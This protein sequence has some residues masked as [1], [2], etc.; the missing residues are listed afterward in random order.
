MSGM[1]QIRKQK[2]Y[3]GV[4]MSPKFKGWLFMLVQVILLG[5]LVLIPRADDWILP[6]WLGWASGALIVLGIFVALFAA[7]GLGGSLTPN[8]YPKYG[9]QLI[10]SGAYKYVR[11]PI[12]SGLLLITA[13]AVL[14]AGNFLRLLLGLVI[15][16]FFIVKA[17]WE[18]KYLTQAYGGYEDYRST[19]PMFFPRADSL[20][21]IFN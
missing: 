8:P 15:V 9:A 2:N 11:H 18:E 6:S 20:F 4:H 7:M 16:V 5:A 10:T 1:S 3:R 12:Y 17:S 21:K 14:G 13:G 19:T